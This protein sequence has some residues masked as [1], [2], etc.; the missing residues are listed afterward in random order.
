MQPWTTYPEVG[1]DALEM[2][3]RLALA[4][5]LLTDAPGLLLDEPTASLDGDGQQTFLQIASFLRRTSSRTS[6]RAARRDRLS[7]IDLRS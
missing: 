3:Q 6:T 2:Q 7:V 1:F 4:Q 5:V